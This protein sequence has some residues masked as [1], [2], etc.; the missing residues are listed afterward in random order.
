M[1]LLDSLFRSPAVDDILSDKSFIQAMLDFEASLAQAESRLGL[2]PSAAAAAI[3]SKCRAELFDLGAIGE[4]AASAGTLAIP[5]VKQLTALVTQRDKEAARFVHWG[6]TSQDVMDTARVLQLRQALDLIARDLDGMVE[7]LS[8]MAQKH[9]STLMAGRTWMQQALPITLGVKIA[10]WL[11]ALVRHSARLKG[12]R[13]RC[14]ALQF[15]G[16]AGTLAA[17]G[18]RGTEVASFLAAELKL[19]LPDIPWHSHRDRMAE[20]A[21]TLGLCVGTVGKIARDIA[22][23]M[24]TEVGEIFEPAA[25]ERSGSST[26]PHKRNPI[27]A[28]VLLATA[29]R[30]PGLVSTMLVA[31]VQE[32][33]RGLGGWQAE[34]ET[35]P[36]IVGLTAGAVHHLSVLL[37]GLEIDAEHMKRNLD[38]T[39]GLLFAEAVSMALA[40]KIGKAQAHDL[41]QA[42][43][44][45]ALKE[46]RGLRPILSGDPRISA[47]LSATDLDRLFNSHNYLGAA[48][49]FVYRVVAASRVRI[50]AGEE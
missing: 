12:A 23:H 6:A 29:A 31:M 11:D 7:P 18:Q 8:R 40:E 20:I 15:G 3:A 16:A 25:E 27:T 49:E 44:M 38:L 2:I 14:L 43:C 1:S 4:S 5:L 21:T 13:E 41:V 50:P 9:R 47:H 34:W 37:P 19:G 33:E 30:V 24:Q 45:R 28:S 36:E 39:D 22:L 26:L 10:G 48:D 17:L 35:L 32:D 46:K 42:A